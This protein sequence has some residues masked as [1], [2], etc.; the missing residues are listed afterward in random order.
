MIGSLDS[1]NVCLIVGAVSVGVDHR[2][3]TVGCHRLSV[4]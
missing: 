4:L 2:V 3:H 1:K